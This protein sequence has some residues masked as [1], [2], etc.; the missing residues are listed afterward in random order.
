MDGMSGGHEHVLLEVGAGDRRQ[1]ELP[2]TAGRL[3][4]AYA[5]DALQGG[6]L[7]RVLDAWRAAGRPIDLVH[8]WGDRS[9]RL[10]AACLGGPPTLAT[11]DSMTLDAPFIDDLH[12][13]DSVTSLSLQVGSSGMADSLYD[14]GVEFE[15]AVRPF[16][17]DASSHGRDPA[18]REAWGAGEDT[19]VFGLVADRVGQTS[20][21]P[22]L[23]VPAR[24]AIMGRSVRIVA[25]GGAE[26]LAA[27]RRWLQGM[28]HGEHLIADDTVH[29]PASIASLDA[30]M[31]QGSSGRCGQVAGLLPI[32]ESLAESRP[33]LL[34]HGHPAVGDL[35]GCPLVCRDVDHRENEACR[36]LLSDAPDVSDGVGD[37]FVDVPVWCERLQQDYASLA[38]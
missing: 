21:R 22:L 18:R 32:L 12:E 14:A 26:D 36:W 15:L 28:G 1:P 4:P 29:H 13:L 8:V 38:E 7:G 16:G 10:R 33:V 25:P 5:L 2:R 34:G 24:L 3:G 35:T 31:V 19:A 6:P 23:G 11:L 9:L 37:V 30:V 20:L 27:C 17:L